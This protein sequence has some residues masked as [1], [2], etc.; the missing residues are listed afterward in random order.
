M[1]R[2]NILLLTLLFQYNQQ[3]VQ[4]TTTTLLAVQLLWSDLDRLLIVFRY[5]FTHFPGEC[6]MSRIKS[7][8][9]SRSVS[10]DARWLHRDPL[11]RSDSLQRCIMDWTAARTK[12]S[13]RPA[14]SLHLHEVALNA[15]DNDGQGTGG[16]RSRREGSSPR[17]ER[18]GATARRSLHHGLARVRR[19]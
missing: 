11:L 15:C 6:Y 4:Q 2:C 7:L 8:T 18:G 17:M 1:D 3:S 5:I 12:H 10:G 9:M 16:T 13:P 14:S 19:S